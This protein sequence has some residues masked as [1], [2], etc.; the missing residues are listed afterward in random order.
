MQIEGLLLIPTSEEAMLTMENQ[1][2]V[3]ENCRLAINKNADNFYPAPN[4][5]FYA[6]STKRRQF[7]EVSTAEA[8]V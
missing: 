2:F 3:P 7:M 8:I 5:K 4:Y 6:G 1:N